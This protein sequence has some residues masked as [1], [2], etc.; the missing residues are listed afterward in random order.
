M[1]TDDGLVNFNEVEIVPN[2]QTGKFYYQVFNN[3]GTVKEADIG[4]FK[5]LLV[6]T[7]KA[8]SETNEK[9]DSTNPLVLKAYNRYKFYENQI[10]IN[11][12]DM[13]TAMLYDFKYWTFI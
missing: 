1:I 8:Y 12:G 10:Q 4:T 11:N 13:F 2:T 5:N 9:L 7:A 3:P 6:C